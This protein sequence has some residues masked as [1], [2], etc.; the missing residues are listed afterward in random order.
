MNYNDKLCTLELGA[1]RTSPIPPPFLRPWFKVVTIHIN[2]E[3]Q[4][5]SISVSSSSSSTGVEDL[6]SMDVSPDTNEI[7]TI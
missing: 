1:L 4:A 5:R 2:K 6:T 3:S 7:T